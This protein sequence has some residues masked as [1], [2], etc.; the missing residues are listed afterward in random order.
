MQ[1]DPIKPMLKAPKTNRLKLKI[2]VLLSN[3]AFKFNLRRHTQDG[4]LGGHMVDRLV[5]ASGAGA[6][7]RSHIRST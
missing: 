7:T 4:E 3:F 1:F 2:G 5:A 6:Y